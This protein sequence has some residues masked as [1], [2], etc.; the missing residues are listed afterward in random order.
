[1]IELD[2]LKI[3]YIVNKDGELTSK[4][5]QVEGGS[6]A[7]LFSEQLGSEISVMAG[8]EAMLQ[9][10]AANR[11]RI[12]WEF[13]GGTGSREVGSIEIGELTDEE[14]DSLEKML[15]RRPIILPENSAVLALVY[16]TTSNMKFSETVRGNLKDFSFKGPPY[17]PFLDSYLYTM[18]AQLP[19]SFW[20]HLDDKDYILNFTEAG[21]FSIDSP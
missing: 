3:T 4:H 9:E 19:F 13:L 11:N 15:S 8:T 5:Q 14:A 12:A 6:S 18:V 17:S 7:S 10:Q 16:P 21:E 20:C 2:G 1:M